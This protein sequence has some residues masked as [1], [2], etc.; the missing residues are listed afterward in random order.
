MSA[1]VWGPA[2][3]LRLDEIRTVCAVNLLLDDCTGIIGFCTYAAEVRAALED[4]HSGQL[5][6]LI[7]LKGRF[8][9]ERAHQ[10]CC[11]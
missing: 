3:R 9:G 10:I 7:N 1:S 11:W 5:P 6:D 2:G 8:C 4:T